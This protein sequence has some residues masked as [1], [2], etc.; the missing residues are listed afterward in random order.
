MT[1]RNPD[2][3]A[4]LK[5]ALAD[6]AETLLVELFGE[7]NSRRGREWRWGSKGSLAYRFDRRTFSNFETGAG[8]RLLDAVMHR[9]DCSFPQAVTWARAWLGDDA[10][11]RPKPSPRKRPTYDADADEQ[12]RRTEA[13][14]LW[15]AGRGINGTAA[16]RYLQGRAI[17][18]WPAD[19]V[20]LIG[21][22]DVAR[23]AWSWWRWPAVMFPLTSG[24]GTVTAVH[25]IALTDQGEA[26]KD[27]DGRKLKR[28]RGVMRGSAVRLPGDDAGALLLLAEGG[29]DALSI[30]LATGRTTWAIVGAIGRAPLDDVPVDCKIGVCRDDDARNAPSRKALRDAIKKWR[31]DGRHVVEAQPWS[32]SRGDKSDF[33]DVLQADG[34]AAVRDRIEAA[35]TPIAAPPGK[36]RIQ[37]VQDLAGAISRTIAELLSWGGGAVP[38]KVIRATLGLG[39]SEAALQKFIDV[40]QGAF[41]PGR[42]IIYSAPMHTLT[43]ELADRARRMA[44]KRGLDIRVRVWR[45]READNPD[46]TGTMCLDVATVALARAARQDVAK[47]VCDHCVH[48][49][50]CAHIAQS[51]AE[52]DLWLVPHTLLFTNLPAAMKNAAM[53]LIDESIVLSGMAPHSLVRFDDLDKAVTRGRRPKPKKNAKP[54]SITELSADL[55]AALVPIHQKL[56]GADHPASKKGVPLQREMLAGITVEMADDARRMNNS[57]IKDVGKLD[58]PTRDD[59]VRV[60]ARLAIE[61]R[62]PSQAAILWRHIRDFLADDGAAESGRIEVIELADGERAF[63]LNGLDTRGDGWTALPTLH[64]DATANMAL[65]RERFPHADLVADVVAAEPHVTVHQTVGQSF[66]NSSLGIRRAK[67]ATTGKWETTI[68]PTKL[69]DDVRR[70]VLAKSAVLA[71]RTLVVAPK[72]LAQLWRKTF[73]DYVGVEWFGNLRGIDKYGDVSQVILVGRWGVGPDDVGRLAGILTGRAVPRIDGWYPTATV[74]LAA[75]DGSTRTV[76]ADQHPD[77]LADAVRAAL[78]VD[79]LLQ[80]GGRGRGSQRGPANPL[81]IEVYGNTPLPLRLASISDWTAPGP[82][83]ATLADLGA[84]LA[85]PTDAAEVTGKS[86]RAVTVA[87]QRMCTRPYKNTSL[88]GHVH[89]LPAGLA[90]ATYQRKGP[91]RGEQRVVYDPRRIPDPKAWLEARLGALVHFEGDDGPEAPPPTV[92]MPVPEIPAPVVDPPVTVEWPAVPDDQAPAEF[93]EPIKGADL[94]TPNLGVDLPEAFSERYAREADPWPD[95]AGGIMPGE[96]RDQV[97]GRWRAADMTQDDLAR[98]VGISRPQLANALQGRFGLS[99]DAA[100]RLRAVVASLP[101][102]QASLW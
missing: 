100:A 44:A 67:N 97:R 66:S 10:T 27:K 78:V 64:L 56:L 50:G 4:A 89:N 65:V 24:D 30:W 14:A 46:G 13:T 72:A 60:L 47:T 88:Y 2:D 85:S 35:L 58:A 55:N 79:E 102:T 40:I 90:A 74:T 22:R 95:F 39:K 28:T 54:A 98:L 57:R 81:R 94:P 38:L 26:I 11:A 93:L 43:A 41:I 84:W 6:N 45:G 7:P 34:P 23:I 101:V 87:R 12:R 52:A 17:D 91:G 77:P 48:R 20:R 53:L 1:A 83:E 76:D 71:G 86:A 9:D 37:A 70:D 75:A 3:L 49:F 8:G 92:S 61:N 80:G 42:P 25:L 32:L 69:A 18:R 15:R 51:A 96:M 21:A 19:S 29:E 36:P 62:A 5:A 82:D 31:R 68:T 63:R 73:P 99:P 59:L 33:N 16:A